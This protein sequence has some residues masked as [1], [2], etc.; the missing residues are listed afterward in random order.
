VTS[1]AGRRLPAFRRRPALP[2]ALTDRLTPELAVTLGVA[3]VLAA[4]AFYAQGGVANGPNTY[5][6]VLLVAGGGLL[7]A[8]ALA[9]PGRHARIAP[10]DGGWALGLFGLL[11]LVTAFSIVW[12]ID[13]ATAWLETNRTFAY[14]AAFGGGVALVRLLP[15]HWSSLLNGVALAAV[16]VCGYALLTK[17]FP[18]ALAADEIFARLRAPF[19]YWNAVGLMAASGV[20]PLVWLA[21][22]RSGHAA[23]N[24]LAYPGLGL[25]LVCLLLA[26]SRGALL[27]L[28]VGLGFWFAVVPLRLRGAVA[29]I[30]SSAGAGLVVAWAFS[31]DGLTEDRLDTVV[32]ADAGHELG[33]LLAL[34]V[35]VLLAAGLAIGFAAA[36]RAPSARTRELAGRAVLATF[37]LALVAGIVALAAAPGGVD[38]QVSKAWHQLTDVNAKT[39]ANTPDRLT[40]TASVRARY[41]HEAFKVHADSELVGAGAGGYGLARKRFRTSDLDVQHAHGYVVQT[42]ADLGWL[43]LIVSLAALVAWVNA[44][45]RATGL[46]RRDRGLAWD[47]ERVGLVTIGAVVLVFGVHSFVDWTWFVPANAVTALLCAGW[48]AGRGPLRRRLSVEGPTG[49]IGA[50]ERAGVIDPRPRWSVRER[51]VRWNPD[52]FRTASAAG[53]LLLAMAVMFTTVQPLRAQHAGDVAIARLSAGQYAAAADIARRGARRNPLSP[54]PWWELAVIRATTNDLD[55]AER[56]LEEAVKVQPANPEAWRRLGRFR[57][58]ALQEPALALPAFRAALYLDPQSPYSQSDV[59]EATRAVASTA[60]P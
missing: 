53:V 38:G 44:A 22:R 11:A 5:A 30:V 21:A 19:G 41:W 16:I 24:A 43:G 7:G 1:L 55:G 3:F 18:G 40:A 23:V 36:V 51:L 8:T 48:L 31:Q 45:T 59:L 52:P 10:M 17:V 12:A 28:A 6:E 35:V 56:A 15:H 14:L 58:S 57:L 32:R 50:A 25:L 54:D 33:I 46:R 29:L 39:P 9:S 34:M 27:A 49:V 2:T 37:A 13:P 20:P 4:L 47:A 42:L 26:Y 60:A